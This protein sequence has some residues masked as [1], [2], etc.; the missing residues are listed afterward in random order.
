MAIVQLDG[1]LSIYENHEEVNTLYAVTVNCSR[2]V[3]SCQI[4]SESQETVGRFFGFEYFMG[5]DN[6]HN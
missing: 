5:I 4:D 2:K 1:K 6:R 3:G